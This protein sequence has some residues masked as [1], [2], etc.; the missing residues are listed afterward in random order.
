MSS[1]NQNKKPLY[2]RLSLYS[3]QEMNPG[4]EEWYLALNRIVK[5]KDYLL[6]GS[7]F[8]GLGGTPLPTHPLSAPL[9]SNW[10]TSGSAL[11]RKILDYQLHQLLKELQ[12]EI[13]INT[14][15]SNQ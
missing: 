11:S 9:S 15:S 10:V 4:H 14:Y 5:W 8:E 13:C 12:A 1:A 7:V 2:S 3:V 6:E